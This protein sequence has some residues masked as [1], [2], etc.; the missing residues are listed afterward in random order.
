M[1]IRPLHLLFLLVVLLPLAGCGD[2]SNSQG[3]ALVIDDTQQ[4]DGFITPDGELPNIVTGVTHC[5]ADAACD[6]GLDCTDDTCVDEPNQGK[7]CHWEVAAGQCL[8]ANQCQSYGDKNPNNSCE[9]CAAATPMQWSTA[10]DGATCDDGDAC[11]SGTTC[12]A[13]ACEGG[14][15]IDCDDQNDCTIDLCD[16]QTGCQSDPVDNALA[17]ACDDGL[18][19]TLDD[20]CTDGACVGAADPCDDGDVCTDGTCEEATGCVQSF[21]S[22]PCDDGLLCT[23]DSVCDQGT[24]GGG[25]PN[26]CDDGNECTIDVCDEL[27]GCVWLP[28]F[29]PCCT[30]TVSV[31]DDGDLCT[32]DICDPNTAECSYAFSTSACNDSNACT[33][34]DTCDQ[35]V[36]SGAA[37]TCDDGNDCTTDT[38]NIGIGCTTSP[39]DGTSCDDGLACSTGDACV[40]GVCKA[41][42]S[43]CL[44][45]PTFGDAAKVTSML[46]GAN[47]NAGEALDIDGDG[48]LDNGLAALGSLVNTPLQDAVTAGS[49]ML[50]F[51]GFQTGS[52]DLSLFQ[53]DLDPA[54][55]TCE[56]L[57]ATCD[58]LADRNLLDSVTC[59]PLVNLPANWTG[60]HVTAG[61]PTTIMPFSLPLDATTTLDLTL[62]MVNIDFTVTTA[63]GQV[64]GLTG[65][66]GGAATETDLNAAIRSLDPTS[67]PNNMSPDDL[68][69]L[70]GILA[71]NDT[72]TDGDGTKD[73]KSIG[74]K[75]IGIDGKLVGALAP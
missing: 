39:L 44:C 63:N 66:L 47:Q 20:V 68:I 67:L 14:S 45:T 4:S 43:Q 55:A 23:V 6:D 54:N 26:L 41:D 62:Y 70:L 33:T 9:L 60:T 12:V 75:L 50:L 3:D 58:Y 35:G 10:S 30:G 11:T 2:D 71:P 28:T 64:N 53:A 38:C 72:D 32:T 34:N 73:A 61:G 56:H 1:T 31:C 19:C 65:L 36:C 74:L 57:T 17:V 37:L 22:A 29:N 42:T 8:I 13:G 16:P 69:N 40:L 59:D 52:F 48:T 24:C 46:I 51:E 27:A 49:I 5:E 18:V 25:Q 21:N 15:T 7:I